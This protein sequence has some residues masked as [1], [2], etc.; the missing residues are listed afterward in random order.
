MAM[1]NASRGK[2]SLS[3]VIPLYNA[4]KFIAD[5]LISV[6]ALPMAD[7]EV[8]VV[9]DGSTDRS[10]QICVEMA[11]K[12]TRIR[13]FHTDHSGAAHARSYGISRA[14]GEYLWFVDSDDRINDQVF[15]EDIWPQMDGGRPA[16]MVFFLSEYFDPTFTNRLRTQKE[17]TNTGAV[18]TAGIDLFCAYVRRGEGHEIGTSPCNKL[19]R[20]DF[21]K[22]N[23][24]RFRDDLRCHEE[25]EF[26]PRAIYMGHEFQFINRFGYRVRC[27]EESL[28]NHKSIAAKAE[29]MPIKAKLISYAR[30]N[31]YGLPAEKRADLYN[32]YNGIFL[33]GISELETANNRLLHDLILKIR[34]Y[35]GDILYTFRNSSSRYQRLLLVI[36]RCFGWLP[37]VKY[38]LLYGKMERAAHKGE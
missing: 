4:E 31:G 6:A 24:L 22:K 17:Y 34:E 37:M 2:T 21:L 19:F 13:L 8:I 1:S 28:S 29:L 38:H 26:I 15:Y 30:A 10:A 35:K 11:K 32:Y 23:A 20:T 36:L 33:F 9:D 25:D 27:R 14:E 3:V 16:D 7:M 5:A 18:N 12:D